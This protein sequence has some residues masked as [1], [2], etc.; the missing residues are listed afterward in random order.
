MIAAKQL[1][2][3]EITKL[4]SFRLHG[5]ETLGTAES[6]KPRAQERFLFLQNLSGDMCIEIAGSLGPARATFRIDT[7]NTVTAQL[8]T[9]SSVLAFHLRSA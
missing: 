4:E 5:D 6:R 8:Q 1:L 3:S 2:G 9:L 7:P